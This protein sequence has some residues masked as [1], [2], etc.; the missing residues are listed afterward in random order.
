MPDDNGEQWLNIEPILQV[1][2]WEN[3]VQSESCTFS[4]L[5]HAL[6]YDLKVF[7]KIIVS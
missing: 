4:I 1:Y 3:Y 2:K 7:A 5:D 6:F